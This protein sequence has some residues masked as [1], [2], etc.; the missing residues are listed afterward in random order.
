MKISLFGVS[1]LRG[2]VYSL[3]I[4]YSLLLLTSMWNPPGLC[5]VGGFVGLLFGFLLEFQDVSRLAVQDLTDG[6]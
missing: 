5:W 3:T 4:H 6:L 1:I 2:T